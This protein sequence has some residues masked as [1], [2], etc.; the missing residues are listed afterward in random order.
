M[1]TETTVRFTIE[2]PASIVD[3]YEAQ[4]REAHKSI[5]EYLILRLQNCS[6]YSAQR[7][8]YFTDQEREE[9]EQILGEGYLNAASDVLRQ[10]RNRYTIAIGG[11][12][13][14]LE[15]GLYQILKERSQ[16]TR[17]PMRDMVLRACR[18]GLSDEAWG[19]H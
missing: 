14:R 9:V 15:E 16:E 13:I 8:L 6:T 18:N 4:A 11:A 17:E 5:E 2:L 3:R 12:H 10:L 19:A 1:P 7:P